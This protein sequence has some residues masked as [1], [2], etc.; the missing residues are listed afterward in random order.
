MV[1]VVRPL[2]IKKGLK[3]HIRLSLKYLTPE[4]KNVTIRLDEETKAETDNGLIRF[5]LLVDK[6][7]KQSVK[8]IFLF[9]FI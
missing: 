6:L 3:Y 5:F 2:K 1:S 9:F 4:F 8:P 7:L